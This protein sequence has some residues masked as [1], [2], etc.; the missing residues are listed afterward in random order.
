MTLVSPDSSVML[1]RHHA[2][3]SSSSPPFFQAS[4]IFVPLVT[5]SPVISA[6]VL[7]SAAACSRSARACHSCCLSGESGCGGSDITALAVFAAPAQDEKPSKSADG[8]DDAAAC[9]CQLLLVYASSTFA[10]ERVSCRAK[11]LRLRGNDSGGNSS[12]SSSWCF[13]TEVDLLH[14]PSKDTPHFDVT[15]IAGCRVRLR[16]VLA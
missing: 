3:S 4:T 15:C 8:D 12:S 9:E 1:H 6:G 10:D 11:L 16:V 13:T 2:Q 5:D 14:P 7:P